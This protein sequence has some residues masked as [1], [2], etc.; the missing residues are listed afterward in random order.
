MSEKNEQ[1]KDTGSS[2]A[3]AEPSLKFQ[4]P[5]MRDVDIF[6]LEDEDG[7]RIVRTAAELEEAGLWPGSETAP[8][9]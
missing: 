8:E 2:P 5:E 4:L 9:E 1:E 7:E 3:I 6:V